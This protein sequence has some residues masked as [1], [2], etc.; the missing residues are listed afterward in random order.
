MEQGVGMR[1]TKREIESLERGNPRISTLAK[2]AKAMG[3]QLRIGFMKK[4]RDEHIQ[5][6]DS[7]TEASQQER[8]SAS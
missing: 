4:M 5:T 6:I 1:L 7:E 8:V 2:L 3:F